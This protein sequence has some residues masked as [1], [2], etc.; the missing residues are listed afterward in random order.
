MKGLPD[1]ALERG[2]QVRQENVRDVNRFSVPDPSPG[3][4]PQLTPSGQHA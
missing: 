3:P 1:L 4:S 2:Q